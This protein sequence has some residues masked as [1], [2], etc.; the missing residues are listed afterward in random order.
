MN[1]A[2]IIYPKQKSNPFTVLTLCQGCVASIKPR[3]PLLITE[4]YFYSAVKLVL[5]QLQGSH[6]VSP[7]KDN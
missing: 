5:V 3:R 1:T 6:K 7:S 2:T 4:Q